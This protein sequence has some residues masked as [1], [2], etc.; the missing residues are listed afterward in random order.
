MIVKRRDASGDWVVYHSGFDVDGDS[1]PETDYAYLNNNLPPNDYADFWNDTAPSDA[2]FSLGSFSYVNASGGDY[3]AYLFAT[4]LGV[5][6]VGS[7]T[8]TGTGDGDT[9]NIDCGFSAG[10]RFVLI[11]RTDTS[12]NWNVYD[13]ER[14]INASADDK[15]LELNGTGA[16]DTNENTIEPLASGFTVRWD[17]DS[18]ASNNPNV[19]NATYIFLAIA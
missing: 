1:A 13:T 4:L 18:S 11:K 8:G 7:Y 14:G 19:N 3:I 5:S 17:T 12:G 6:K 16:E 9:L 2:S 15:R 10:A